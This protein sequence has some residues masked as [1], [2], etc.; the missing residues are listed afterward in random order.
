[1]KRIERLRDSYS[2]HIRVPWRGA[3]SAEE[4][5]IFCI[6]DEADE[7]ILR[8]RIDEFAEVTRSA[9]HAWTCVDLTD[10]FG[11]WLSAQKYAPKYFQKPDL[12]TAAISGYEQY[13][14]NLVKVRCTEEAAGPNHVVA[15]MG[16]GDLFGL[17]KV[18]E[19][20]SSI[21]PLVEGRLVVFFPGSYHGNNY[22]FMDAYDGWSYL[23][24]PI[25]AD[26]A[27]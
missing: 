2:R 8:P 17:L 1:M 12:L 4:R 11:R 5:V 9:G 14:V 7:L 19:L 6:Y 15:L 23:A 26:S 3:L 21:V 10:S 24:V 25:T 16:L 20:I 13:L 22:R 18:R 27:D